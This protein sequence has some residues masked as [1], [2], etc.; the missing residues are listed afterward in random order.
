[1]DPEAPILDAVMA[2]VIER[3]P[4]ELVSIID[5]GAGPLT[6]VGKAHPG[7]R[8]QITATDP[9][10]QEY[11]RIMQAIDFEPPVRTTPVS[12]EALLDHFEPATFDIAFARNSVDHS[13]NPVLVIRNMVELVKPGRFVVLW[14]RPAEAERRRYHGL[15]QWNFGVEDDGLV[16][17]R[18]R[19][20]RV[21]IDR[22]L[23]A[24]ASVH[25]FT[26]DGWVCCLLTRA[27]EP[28]EQPR[29]D[30]RGHPPD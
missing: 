24:D 30:P 23:G 6:T 11:D 5:V 27:E 4:G 1:M 26:R 19:R 2:S 9:L 22:A 20:E 21:R 13:I 25:C 8:L 17:W 18:S 10:A 12:G 14:H 3:V 16:I 7:K 15:H 28:G 29:P